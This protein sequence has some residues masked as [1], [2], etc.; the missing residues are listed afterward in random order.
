[1]PKSQKVA[2]RA[3]YK[4]WRDRK[5]IQQAY[6]YECVLNLFLFYS[7]CCPRISNTKAVLEHE[8]AEDVLAL[9]ATMGEHANST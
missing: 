5:P 7:K 3:P 1:M 2:H 4:V 9:I 8:A 6:F